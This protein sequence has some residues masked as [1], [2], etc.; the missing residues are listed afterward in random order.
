M[1]YAIFA[2]IRVKQKIASS[3]FWRKNDNPANV[4]PS[5]LSISIKSSSRTDFRHSKGAKIIPY[6]GG[7]LL[8]DWIDF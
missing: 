2:C 1:A 6:N 4:P 3:N 5:F 8:Q 7:R